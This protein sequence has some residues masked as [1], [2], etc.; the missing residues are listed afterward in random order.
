VTV[1]Q[2][3]R[4]GRYCLIFSSASL[5]YGLAGPRADAPEG[6]CG[7]SAK[8][9]V[10]QLLDQA[11]DGCG[12]ARADQFDPRDGVTPHT[13]ILVP[14]C[15]DQNID[16]R[17]GLG[18]DLNQRF[19]CPDSRHGIVIFQGFLDR[20]DG[21]FG[22]RPYLAQRVYHVEIHL[23][24]FF[25]SFALYVARQLLDQRING[26]LARG[27]EPGNIEGRFLAHLPVCGRQL[28]D[29]SIETASGGGDGGFLLAFV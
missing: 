10:R 6:T 2:P 4:R 21:V 29:P 25:L 11:R 8:F 3:A 26:R 7:M 20:L 5:I 28:A 24:S 12:G 17:L 14:Q 9:R 22:T 18:I 13:D 27:A 23:P 16:T 15:L 1:R 19:D